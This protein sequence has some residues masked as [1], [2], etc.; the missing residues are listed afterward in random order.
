M[1]SDADEVFE[2]ALEEAAVPA[3]QK[4][5]FSRFRKKQES[6]N[7]N[8]PP[9][10]TLDESLEAA[11]ESINKFLNNKF[12]EA[13][14]IVE[15]LAENSI[16]HALGWGVIMYLKA[17]MTFEEKHIEEASA[18]LGRACD[19][20]GSFRKKSTG[21]VDSL[22]SILRKPDY[23]AY[24]DMEVHAELCFAEVLLLKASLTLCEDETLMSFVKAGMKV[25]TCYQSFRE[26]WT[27][28]QHR[29]WHDDQHRKDF[30]SGVRMGVGCFNLM[31][32]LLPA[33]V[34]KLLEWIG[35]G[36]NKGGKEAGLRELNRV[37][38]EKDG[39]RQFLA[40]MV[41]L[42]YHLVLS[43]FIGNE[44]QHNLQLCQEILQ[45]KLTQYPN[46]A[47]FLFFKGRYHFIQGQMTEAIHWYKASCDSQNEWPQFHHVCYW[48]LAWAH[49]FSLN[50]WGAH[51]YANLLFE[52][53]RWSRCFYA[54]QQAAMM[55]MVQGELSQDQRE[56][57]IELMRH[58]PS[59]KQR[60]AGKSL[61]MEKFAVAKA[62]RFLAQGNHLVLPALE[63]IYV[64]NGFKILG[65]SWEMMEPVFLLVEKCLKDIEL[66]KE[67]RQFYLEDFALCTLLRGMCLKYMNLPL[68]AEDCYLTVIGHKGSLKRDTYLVPYAMYERALILKDKDI[69]EAM[70]LLEKAKSEHKDY[71]L[72][73]RLHFR[74][75]SA[76]TEIR[77]KNKAKK[78][79]TSQND[80]DDDLSQIMP[81]IQTSNT[82]SSEILPMNEEAAMKALV[83]PK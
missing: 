52:E 51:K 79:S 17:V 29:Q 59:W 60:I 82:R 3:K 56:D 26:C 12:D 46:G 42:G 63:L 67:T 27:I 70:D 20:I 19:T 39:L 66:E 61:P 71:L 30:E 18:I 6:K 40:S 62:D 23:D 76:Q 5:K 2:D 10:I 1:D 8:G 48:E 54:Y 55:C 35:F 43:V 65:K 80:I 38:E 45:Q 47:F 74:I 78:G 28:M 72:Q 9:D 32:S 53:S 58:V 57:Q 36:G 24:T 37:Y 16:Y 15:P 11:R 69:A 14:D 4:R 68:Q 34:M 73:S 33:R 83:Q 75:H 13:R 49:Q 31:I 77:A 81:P 25:R 22:G 21:L 64:W 50:W 44:E 7:T 41:L